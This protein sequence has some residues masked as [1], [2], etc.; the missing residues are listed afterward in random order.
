MIAT[1]RTKV[2]VAIL[3]LILQRTSAF[4]KTPLE[5]HVSHLNMKLENTPI[6]VDISRFVRVGIEREFQAPEINTLDDQLLLPETSIHSLS[7]GENLG[8]LLWTFVLYQGLF[9]TSGRP[10]DWIVKPLAILFRKT[11][12]TWYQDYD[13]GY[14]FE[15][16]PSIELSR[17][18]VFFVLSV[19][20]NRLL[21][22]SLGDDSF[23]GWSIGACLAIPSAL[24]AL[25]R[26][27]PPTREV[28]E[29]QVAIESDFAEFA[30]A[31]LRTRKDGRVSEKR[32]IE[33][34]RRKSKVELFDEE[35]TN[36]LLRKAI[37][38][39]LG[40]KPENGLYVGLEIIPP[41]RTQPV[42]KEEP[43]HSENR[44]RVEIQVPVSER[45]SAAGAIFMRD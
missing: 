33:L 11:N 36:P 17:I 28:A 7:G 21:I 34:F 30:R 38:R 27:K 45:S 26:D 24:I 29:F 15:C 40:R 20:W 22:N 1:T 2:L 3:V 8:I 42:P 6:K 37:R 14:Y 16:P 12:E 31:V 18:G 23:W 32:L 43:K 39:Y 25:S 13:R 35:K 9:T 4:H 19:A 44:S 41:P 10:A 5:R